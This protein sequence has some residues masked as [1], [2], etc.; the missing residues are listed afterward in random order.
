MAAIPQVLS[1]SPKDDFDDILSG[2]LATIRL[3]GSV[4]FCVLPA[5]DWQAEASPAFIE[6]AG[7]G[8]MPFHIVAEGQCWLERDGETTVL[9]PGDIILFPRAVIHKLGAGRGGEML[10]ILSDLPAR[11]WREVPV[12]RYGEGHHDARILCGFFQC[13]DL[14]FG[15]LA[16]ALPRLIHVRTGDGNAWLSGVIR[17][18]VEE[19]KRPRAGGISVLPRLTEVAFIEI[20]R[21]QIALSGPQSAGWLAAMNDPRLAR[22]LALIHADPG[23]DWSVADLAAQSGMSRSAMM[24][25]FQSVLSTSPIK[26]I[27]D[28]RLYL[29]SLDLARTPKPIS[30]VALGSG[31]ATEA[32]FTR[33]FARAFGDPPAAWRS[34][35]RQ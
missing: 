33:A 24:E 30:E 8:A 10:D 29:A 15:P 18:M 3:S 31:Y 28:W 9:E 2:L 25:R 32:A 4:Q 7:P 16:H 5:G 17:Q 14:A 23:R 21:D 35:A 6:M 27:R 11:P 1:Q 19:I 13:D 26:Y 34:R 22:C 20:L 12:L